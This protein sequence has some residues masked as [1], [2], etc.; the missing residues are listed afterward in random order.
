MEVQGET[1]QPG[2]LRD[3]SSRLHKMN[4]TE[5]IA[6]AFEPTARQTYWDG[7]AKPPLQPYVQTGLAEQLQHGDLSFMAAGRYMPQAGRRRKKQR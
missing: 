2:A 1:H 3:I 5:D 6:I 4:L 7:T